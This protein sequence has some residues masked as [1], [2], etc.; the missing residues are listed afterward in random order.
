MASLCSIICYDQVLTAKVLADEGHN[1]LKDQR[2]PFSIHG[3]GL[4][5]FRMTVHSRTLVCHPQHLL[6][7]SSAHIGGIVRSINVAK[8]AANYPQRWATDYCILHQIDNFEPASRRASTFSRGS[9][10][11]QTISAK[12]SPGALST[13]AIF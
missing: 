9:F 1:K 11:D 6:G 5:F 8:S 4:A 2:L 7:P 13:E 10:C 12:Q 3:S